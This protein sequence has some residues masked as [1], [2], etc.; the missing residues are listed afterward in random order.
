MRKSNI[1]LYRDIRSLTYKLN[2]SHSRISA[3]ERELDKYSVISDNLPFVVSKLQSIKDV[4]SVAAI[5]MQSRI[6]V[7]RSAIF[8][9]SNFLNK[10][11]HE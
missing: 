8:E 3:L 2:N 4:L 11:T 7:C 10:I 6:D 1:D 9:L 5:P